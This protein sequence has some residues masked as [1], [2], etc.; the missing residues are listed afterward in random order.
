[1][2]KWISKH[3]LHQTPKDV[4]SEFH[5]EAVFRGQEISLASL[6]LSWNRLAHVAA[7][8]MDGADAQRPLSRDSI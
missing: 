8:R 7:G 4:V 1:M 6:G 5:G 3:R 2:Y